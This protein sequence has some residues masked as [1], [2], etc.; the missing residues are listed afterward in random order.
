MGG[1][2]E[3]EGVG[4]EDMGGA[5][6]NTSSPESRRVHEP[7]RGYLTR[8]LQCCKDDPITINPQCKH[9]SKLLSTICLNDEDSDNSEV[10]NIVNVFR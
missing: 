8:C 5:A 9:S 1:K 10:T 3:R 7:L 2:G 4:R 6:E